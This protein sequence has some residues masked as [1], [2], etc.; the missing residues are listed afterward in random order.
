MEY[1]QTFVNGD[2]GKEFADYSS[3]TWNINGKGYDVF[4]CTLGPA[5]RKHGLQRM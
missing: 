1:R 3:V 4:R 5:R 2:D